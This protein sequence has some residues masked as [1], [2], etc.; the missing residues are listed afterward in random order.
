MP[1]VSVILTSYNKPST[2]TKAIES[3]INQTFQDWEL[4]IM[5]DNSNNETTQI[6]K[7]Y[8]GDP[9]IQYFNSNI[10]DNERFKTARYATL[11]NEAIPKT[12]G[13]YITYLTDDNIFLPERF[14]IMVNYLNQHPNIDI[15][16]SEQHV[17]YFDDNFNLFDEGVRQAPGILNQP[18]CIVDHC[19]VM[20]TRRIA[21]LVFHK[22]GSYWDDHPINWGAGDAAFWVRLTQFQPFYP[23]KKI[24]DI[25]LKYRDSYQNLSSNLPYVI[26]NGTLVRGFKPDIYLIDQQRRRKITE[27]MLNPLKYSEEEVVRIPDPYL[28]RYEEGIPINHMVLIEPDKFPNQR[29]VKSPTNPI[30]YYIQNNKK[31]PIQSVEAFNNFKFR[32]D[33]IVEVNDEFLSKLPN[34]SMICPLAN[35]IITLP[36]GILYQHQNDYYIC[37]NNHLHFIQENTLNKLKLPKENAV[38]MN[39]DLFS[40]FKKGTPI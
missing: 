1:T 19:S 7:R 34:G 9:R 32:W 12:Q 8:L 37:Y 2:I 3:V 35:E 25:A 17:K 23:I 33:K 26:P 27:N 38:E 16:Y 22:Y 39:N 15:V 5:D 14:E 11:I 31:H 13:K 24:L 20:H 21:D 40:Q 36:D 28:F 29:L 18:V 4:F 10:K 30:V 6:I